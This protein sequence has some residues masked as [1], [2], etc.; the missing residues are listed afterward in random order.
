MPTTGHPKYLRNCRYRPPSTASAL[1]P[2]VE[3]AATVLLPRIHARS[4]RFPYGPRTT[5]SQASADAFLRSRIRIGSCTIIPTGR[6]ASVAW[7]Y[8]RTRPTSSPD[9][10]HDGWCSDL[11]R[12]PSTLRSRLCELSSTPP[13]CWSTTQHQEYNQ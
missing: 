10:L 11:P 7:S 8:S 3:L 5:C 9:S 12:T 13:V 2:L 1:D 6:R 4:P